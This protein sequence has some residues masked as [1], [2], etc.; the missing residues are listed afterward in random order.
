VDW[1]LVKVA[2]GLYAPFDDPTDEKS[3]RV[4]VGGLVHG[5]FKKMRNYRFHKKFFA[6]L[7]FAYERWDPGAIDSRFGEPEKNFDRFRKDAI[8]LAGFYN[9]VVRL[10]GTTRIEAD[11][12]SFA[13]MDDERFAAVY[14]GVL[15]VFLKRIPQ[16]AQMGA[17][18]VNAVVDQLIAFG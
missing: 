8:I 2:G 11:S 14:N 16:M 7:N 12:I 4:P 13:N 9:V 6:L 18:E 17:D 1:T 15:N 10:D 5:P 3:K